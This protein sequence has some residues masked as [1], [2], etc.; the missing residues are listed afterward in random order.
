MP[1]TDP[2][3][4]LEYAREYRKNNKEK[5]KEYEKKYRNSD[6]GIKSGRVTNWRFYGVK[7]DDWDKLYEK[8]ISTTN[9]E[10]CNI[11]LTNDKKNKSTTRCLDH[12]HNTGKFRNI[13]C[14]AC[15]T[16]IG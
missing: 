1:I 7:C 10:R 9:C 8:Y 6:K 3:K 16:K 15:N 12:D 13:L 2:I 14:H 11:E 4:R 5:F